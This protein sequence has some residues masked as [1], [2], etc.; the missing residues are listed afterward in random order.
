MAFPLDAALGREPHIK[1][2][3][4]KRAEARCVSAASGLFQSQRFYGSPP[5]PQ[6]DEDEA[7]SSSR[8]RGRDA[9]EEGAVFKALLF[10][11]LL[12]KYL[13]AGSRKGSRRPRP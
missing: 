8:L 2:A 3:K 13:R 5:A 10:V 9:D 6:R 4:R 11:P 1:Y 7:P 12:R